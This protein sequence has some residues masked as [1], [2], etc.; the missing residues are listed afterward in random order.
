MQLQIR[1]TD[2][3]SETFYVD[4]IDE[5][6]HSTNGAIQESN[7]IF[8]Q[9]GLKKCTK[10]QIS[11]FEVGFGTGL[12]AFLTLMEAVH[13]PQKQYFYT[14]IELYPIETEIVIKINY[15]EQTAPQFRDLFEKLHLSEWERAEKILPNFTL[16]KLKADLTTFHTNDSFDVFYF[17]AFSPEK[18][19]EMWNS[20]IF[21]MLYNI[22]NKDAILTTYSAKGIVRRALQS[23][24]FTVE[25]LKGPPGKR[26]IIRA[27]KTI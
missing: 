13:S 17:D 15:P 24:G 14:A 7:H 10:E 18:Q 21:Q 26:E 9:E 11:I 6:Y 12:N 4:E 23:V 1:K 2:D 27:T 20:H 8:I 3:G 25:R 5:C 16:T 22:A 19:P